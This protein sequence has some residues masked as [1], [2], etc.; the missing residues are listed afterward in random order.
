[1]ASTVPSL[2]MAKPA[3]ASP[4]LSPLQ[5]CWMHIVGGMRQQVISRVAITIYSSHKCQQYQQVTA[6]SCRLCCG[7]QLCRQHQLDL[8]ILSSCSLPQFGSS[9][10]SAQYIS[11][12]ET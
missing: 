4:A 9:S 5:S 1:M 7:G 12:A 2:P 10:T 3:Q 6:G 11:W 8:S